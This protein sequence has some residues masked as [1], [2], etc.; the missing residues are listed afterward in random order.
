MVAVCFV[1]VSGCVGVFGIRVACMFIGVRVAV[2]S[3]VR[4]TISACCGV[5]VVDVLWGAGGL[6]WLLLVEV[7]RVVVQVG[8]RVDCDFS[9]VGVFVVAGCVGVGV[10]VFM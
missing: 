6:V 10:G 9:G 1:E 3:V 7:V 4:V 8:L 5:G 2:A